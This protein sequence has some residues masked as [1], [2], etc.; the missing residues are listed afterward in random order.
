MAI[1]YM[2]LIGEFYPDVLAVCQGSPFDYNNIQFESGSVTQAELETVYLTKIKTTKIL[3]F[4][5][6]ARA[7]I[8]AGFISNAMGYPHMYDAEP[9]DQLNLIG[10][11]T[12]QTDVL[13]SSWPS[14]NGR[15]VANFGDAIVGTNA[16]GLP[17]NTANYL[18]EV[19]FN[20]MSTYLSIQGQNAQTFDDLI[21][22]MNADADFSNA[23]IASIVGGNIKIESKLY[24]STSSVQI[25]D[26]TLFAALTGFV[27]LDTAVAG[28]DPKDTPK[29]YKNHTHEQLLTVLN[30]GK[31]VKLTILQKYAVKKA[32]VMAAA[33]EAGV[34]AIVW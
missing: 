3:E 4:S 15:Q 27:G 12:S 21:T 2:N 19:K 22:A 31:T 1:N 11:A 5:E 9:E 16:T 23:G 33:D 26:S 7:E 32:Q 18:A 13:F 8:T 34:N 30:D 10:A 29:E 17:N 14:S 25:I 20:G 6:Y 28:T 24:S